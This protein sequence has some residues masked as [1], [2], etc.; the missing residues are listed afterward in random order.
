MSLIDILSKLEKI[1]ANANLHFNFNIIHIDN[2][3]RTENKDESKTLNIN[4]G[5]LSGKLPDV[6]QEGFNEGASIIDA[7]SEEILRKFTFVKY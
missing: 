4:V 5:D 1:V 6:L 7:E 3:G 2:R